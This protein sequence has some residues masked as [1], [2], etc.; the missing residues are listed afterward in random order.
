MC[1]YCFRNAQ[2]A[3]EPSLI[4]SNLPSLTASF[5]NEQEHGTSPDEEHTTVTSSLETNKEQVVVSK[6]R[7]T[8]T[9]N[10]QIINE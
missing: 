10:L 3:N 8:T 9:S 1:V 5:Q 2:N 7:S 4:E 6:T